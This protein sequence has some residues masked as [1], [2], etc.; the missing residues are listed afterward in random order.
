MYYFRDGRKGR[1]TLP[2]EP[3]TSTTTRPAPVY[4]DPPIGEAMISD[5]IEQLQ[6]IL[7]YHGDQRVSVEVADFQACK[8][9]NKRPMAVPLKLD[10][11]TYL[12]Q[13]LPV[14]GNAPCDDP[15]QN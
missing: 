10:D 7:K 13:I 6:T 4:H 15:P 8:L 2:I 12:C 11:G 9:R 1:A 5:L 3:M 14:T